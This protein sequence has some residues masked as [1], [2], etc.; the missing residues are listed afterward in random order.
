MDAQEQVQAS[1]QPPKIPTISPNRRVKHLALSLIAGALGIAVLEA[2]LAEGVLSSANHVAEIP[3]AR[4]Q[5][6]TVATSKAEAPTTATNAATDARDDGRL[7]PVSDPI[8]SVLLRSDA[9]DSAPVE[10]YAGHTLGIGDTLKVVFY[11]RVSTEDE[12]WGRESSALRGIQQRPELS[13][14]YTIN[15]DGTIS[16]PLL[17]PVRAAARS[18]Q[19]VRAALAEAFEKTL[20]RKAIVDVIQQARSPVYVLGPVKSP[21]SF[22]Y[23]PGMTV[24]HALALAGGLDRAAVEPWQKV[25]AV[26]TI[27]KRSEVVES[28]PKLIARAAVLRAERDGTTPRVPLRLIDLSGAAEADALINEQIDQRKALAMARKDR[29]QA[30]NAAVD[31]ARQDLQMYTR[32]DSLDELVKTRRERL[33]NIRLLVERNTLSKSALDQ[34]QAELSDAEQ[35][36]QDAFNQYSTAKQRL[37]TL[38]AEALR[39]KSDLANDLETEIQTTERQIAENQNEFTTSQQVLSALPATRVDFSKKETT[40]YRIVRQTAGGPVEIEATGMT[41]LQPGDLINVVMGASEPVKQ[42]PGSEDQAPLE[43]AVDQ[44]ETPLTAAEN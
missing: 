41:V 3:A 18:E 33:D 29:E 22:K 1:S 40:T 12:K 25:E 27:Q 37:A 36:R 42:L 23:S 30:A 26:R 31:S 6:R 44:H 43:R 5:A 17:G 16:V 4:D 24:L 2:A 28:M 10:S 15:G 21:G 14:D 34:A 11:E 8:E 13:G 39:T 19:Q 35:R 38:E 32:T 20:G 9:P 7:R